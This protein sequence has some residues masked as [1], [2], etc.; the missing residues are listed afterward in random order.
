GAPSKIGIGQMNKR[1]PPLPPP[2]SDFH[3][4]L[5]DMLRALQAGVGVPG[6]VKCK[7]AVDDRPDAMLFEKE[8]HPLEH[9]ATAHVDA[10]EIDVFG[11][12]R[13]EAGV[14]CLEAG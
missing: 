5:A 6:A 12:D 7:G 14:G 1:D 8:I 2:A 13:K 11:H 9:G 4:D 3:H 10:L